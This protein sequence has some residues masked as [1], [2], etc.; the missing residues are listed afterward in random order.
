MVAGRDLE[1]QQRYLQL[2]AEVFEEISH[3]VS[4]KSKTFTVHTFD[5]LYNVVINYKRVALIGDPG[6]GK[7]TTLE[8]LAHAFATNAIASNTKPIPVFLRLRDYSGGDLDAFILQSLNG[9]SVEKYSPDRLA[10]LF[11]GLNE[12]PFEYVSKIESWLRNN[13]GVLVVVSCR[14]LEYFERKLPL[15]RV[16]I[17]P[18]DVKRIYAFI[19][20]FLKD[21]S[22]DELFWSLAGKE[23]QRAWNW[24]IRNESDASFES[25]WFGRTG[26]VLRIEVEKYHIK[27]IRE[28]LHDRSALPG[29]LGVVSNPFLLT[30]VVYLFENGN[31]PH[32]KSQLF[33]GFVMVLLERRGKP[34]AE[35]RGRWVNRDTLTRA[36]SALA[37]QMQRENKLTIER[38]AAV[39]IITSEIPT[40]NVEDVLFSAISASII[41]GDGHLQFMHQLLQQYFAAYKLDEHIKN[42]VSAEKFWDGERWW[43]ASI[44]NETILF[45]VGMQEDATDIVRWLVDVNPSLAYRCVAKQVW[46]VMLPF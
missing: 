21:D 28:N 24:F 1:R 34:V 19:G 39:A 27:T 3:F 38:D 36:L 29:M 13:P 30:A 43:E 15:Q 20:T 44:W 17:L 25:F 11:D 7:T 22:R 40:V 42:G 9:L 18:L 35:T 23:T 6:C 41:E 8:R 46:C 12:I 33:E 45:L 10:V 37:F 32:N 4:K 2:T 5:E 31:L 26:P 16:D 14:K